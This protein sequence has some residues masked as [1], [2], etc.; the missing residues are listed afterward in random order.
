MFNGFTEIIKSIIDGA[1]SYQVDEDI[2]DENSSHDWFNSAKDIKANSE[3][4]YNSTVYNE[5]KLSKLKSGLILDTIFL[6]GPVLASLYIIELAKS[7]GTDILMVLVIMF[8]F[9]AAGARAFY[10]TLRDYYATVNK[11]IPSLLEYSYTRNVKRK[12]NSTTYYYFV[13]S[14]PN[15]NVLL[16]VKTSKKSYELAE[17]DGLVWVYME[18]KALRSIFESN[19]DAYILRN[20]GEEYSL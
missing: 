11:A 6:V 14:I 13:V 3:Y 1:E 2:L 19:P 15:D 7:V 5:N 18:R 20:L 4:L 17:R 12:D 10:L 9:I 16:T 8:M